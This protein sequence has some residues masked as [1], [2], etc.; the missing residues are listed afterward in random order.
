[1]P[2]K[3]RRPGNS[4]KLYDFYLVQREGGDLQGAAEHAQVQVLPRGGPGVPARQGRTTF[5]TLF[6]YHC[7]DVCYNLQVVM[8]K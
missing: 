1:M 7:V 2:P 6:S 5:G 4:D 8:K 3:N